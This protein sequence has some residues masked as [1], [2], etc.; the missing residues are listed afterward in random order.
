MNKLITVALFFVAINSYSQGQHENAR[1]TG[2]FQSVTG[3]LDIS[4]DSVFN[5]SFTT[6]GGE[7]FLCLSIMVNK[8]LDDVWNTIATE[9][10]LKKWIAPVVSLDLRVGGTIK[11]N[12]NEAAKIGDD[13]TIT[14]GIMSYLPEEMLVLKVALNDKFAEKCRQEDKNLQEII[15]V[16]P[17]GENKT[18]IISTMAGWGQGREWN[19]TYNFFEKG[20]KWT[21]Q[22]LLNWFKK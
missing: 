4:P 21:F 19:E 2:S 11:T 17:L 8:S 6:A 3:S 9:S 14:L 12:Y 16:K 1:L 10:G 15:Q 18:M 22:E 7:K 13:G 5:N 20:N